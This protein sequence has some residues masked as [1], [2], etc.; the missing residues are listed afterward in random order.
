MVLVAIVVVVSFFMGRPEVGTHLL[1]LLMGAFLGS[2]PGIISATR[3]RPDAEND[4]SK[5]K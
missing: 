3:Q 4:P 1:T 5:P 2:V